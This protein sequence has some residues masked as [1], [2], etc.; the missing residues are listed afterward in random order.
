MAARTAVG[1]MVQLPPYTKLSDHP[2]I[3]RFCK[4]VFNLRP[5]TPKLKAV[6]DVNIVFQYFENKPDNKQLADKDL[7]HKLIMLLLLLGGQR[8]NTIVNFHVDSMILTS[9]SVTFAPKSV[10]KHSRKGSKIDSFMYRSYPNKKLCI[11]DCI[12]EYLNRRTDVPNNVT[13]LI[14][15]YGRPKRAASGDTIRRWIKD[16]FKATTAIPNM[17][18]PHSCRSASTSKASLSRLLNIDDIL[19]Q[20]CWRNAKTFQKYYQKEIVSFAPEEDIFQKSLMT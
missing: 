1:Y 18:S 2:A 8:V 17:F 11:V 9:E 14:V 3:N 5:P 12:N 20:G 15:T 7:V 19:Q 10:L 16:L 4:G 13:Q 6:W